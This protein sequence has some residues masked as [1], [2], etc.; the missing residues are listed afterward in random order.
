MAQL[1]QI[2]RDIQQETAALST[3]ELRATIQAS[4]ELLRE[5]IDQLQSIR[6]GAASP[7]ETT[8]AVNDVLYTALFTTL[9]VQELATRPVDR[10]ARVRLSIN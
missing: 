4:L 1:S 9:H 7:E 2:I 6:P 5:Y 3:G 8:S 10:F